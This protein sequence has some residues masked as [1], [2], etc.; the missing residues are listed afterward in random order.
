M[1]NIVILVYT[2]SLNPVKGLR[3]QDYQGI[4]LEGGALFLRE[5]VSLTS[6]KNNKSTSCENDSINNFKLSKSV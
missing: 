1:S 3:T 2:L 5:I 4:Q 6:H